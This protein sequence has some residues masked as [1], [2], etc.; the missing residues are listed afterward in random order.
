MRIAHVIAAMEYGGAERVVVDLASGQARRGLEIAIVAPP[1]MLDR[2]WHALGIDRLP[3]PRA[4]RNP[5]D[6][7]RAERSIRAALREWT[8][9][10][11]HAH[12]VKA[13][14]LTLTGARMPGAR[15]PVLTTLHGVARHQMW[16]TAGIL[17]FADL[18]AA[19]SEEVRGAVVSRGLQAERV[20][21]VHN[22]VSAITALDDATHARYDRELRIRGSV[23]VTVGRL[24]PEKAHDRFL[25][26]ASIVLH[27]NPDTTFLI[28][29][30]GPL[31]RDLERRA[32]ELGIDS[33]VRFTGLRED[34]RLLIERADLFVL[35]S[36]REGHSVAALEALAAGTPVVSTEVGGMRELLGTGAG[37]IVS[38]WEAQDLAAAITAVLRDEALRHKMGEE[39]CRLVAERFS[40]QAME[41][42][43]AEIYDRL[44]R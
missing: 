33:A 4:M 8:P 13:T 14:A 24:V 37:R 34:A 30:D 31:R 17:R 29:G 44:T 11:V 27:S 42:R 32:T 35:S 41:D 25:D 10:V 5:V 19:V 9:D 1:G 26:A 23:V 15:T 22:G 3:T 43:Y 18:V 16:A 28:V 21:V 6:L 7:S 38:S 40:T 20:E 39:G 12:N 36:N 2:A